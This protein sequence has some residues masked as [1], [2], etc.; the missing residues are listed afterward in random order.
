MVQYQFRPP[1]LSYFEA[2]GRA[3]DGYDGALG[4]LFLTMV[5][6]DHQLFFADVRGNWAEPKLWTGNLG[7]GYRRM[8]PTRQD[9]I[10]GRYASI[11]RMRSVHGFNYNQ[12]TLG[13]ELMSVQWDVR[14][15]VYLPELL[16]M[17]L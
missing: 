10:L 15:N 17:A 8:H 16:P 14:G 13:L 6:N 2:G 9:W 1:Y 4:S 11:D 7:F 3:G 5:Q 12:A